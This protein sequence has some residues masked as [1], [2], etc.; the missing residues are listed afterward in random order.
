LFKIRYGA[1]F[2][3]ESV[4]DTGSQGDVKQERQDHTGHGAEAGQ[5]AVFLSGGR[6]GH[7]IPLQRPAVKPQKAITDGVDQEYIFVTILSQTSWDTKM[8]QATIKILAG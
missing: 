7:T 8:T 5:P 6:S 1:E 2:D 4:R 3:E